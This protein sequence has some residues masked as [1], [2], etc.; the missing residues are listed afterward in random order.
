MK[1]KQS[2]AFCLA[3]M[4]VVS[5]FAVAVGSAGSLD[6]DEDTSLNNVSVT[7]DDAIEISH[8]TE[9]DDVRNNLSAD[10][11]LM[12]D[13]DENTEGYDEVASAS[14][15]DGKGF[16]PIG[17]RST[18][19]TGTFDGSE[20]TISNLTI[21]RPEDDM[22]GLFGQIGY[23]DGDEWESYPGYV[24]HVNLKDVN[25]T[26]GTEYVGGV[27]GYF[28]YGS[29]TESSVTG[30]VSGEHKV[31]GLVGESRDEGI[32][33][34]SATA[35]VSGLGDYVG[36]LVGFNLGPVTDS[37][38]TG[39]VSGDG[40]VG[41][42]IGY[43]SAKVS[44][45]YASGNV[46]GNVSVGGLIGDDSYSTVENSHY[47]I[48]E[49]LIN[50]EHHVTTGGL[51]NDQY[52]DWIDDKNLNIGDYGSLESA[53]GHYNISNVQ[54]LRDLLGFAWDDQY[55]FHL[56]SDIV[57]SGEQDLYI[58]YL[59]ADFDG[60]GH[61]VTNVEIDLPFVSNL[62]WVG[63]NNEATVRNIDLIINS[64]SG[65]EGV[66]G[67][68]GKNDGTVEN[69]SATGATGNVSGDSIVG[70][71]VGWHYSGTVTDS[72]ATVNVSGDD[73]VGGLVGETYAD[74]QTSYA[75]G[76]VNGTSRVGGLVGH[77]SYGMV[78]YS[79]ATGNV[80]GDNEV[81][82]L[83]GNN[84]NTVNDA[85]WDTETTGQDT[86]AGDGT[87]L[88]T[89][90]MKGDA[91]TE[92][93]NFDFENT[94]A[95]VDTTEISYPY[96]Q[97]NPQSP[98]PGL[99]S[100]FA[101]GDGSESDPYQIETV[102]QLQS[103][104]EDLPAHYMLISDIDASGTSE[105]N[106]GDGFTPI[107]DDE[108]GDRNQVP[109]TG[110]FDG[111]GYE[112]RDLYIGRPDERYVGLFG[113]TDDN[114][115]IT[116]LGVTDADVSGDEFVGG[117]VGQFWEDTVSGSYATGNVSGN[118]DVGGLIGDNFRG[119]VE[120]SYSTVDVIGDSNVGGL[121]GKNRISGTVEDS[122]FTG[123][124][125]G[126]TSVGGLAGLN[127]GTVSNSHYNIEEVL[128]NG[129]HHVTTSGLFNDQYQDW[130]DDKNLNI[131]DYG[132]LESVEGHY[133]I[134]DVQG[135]RDILGF[136][137]DDQYEFH[138]SS[139]I[140]LS[141][142]QDL[143]IP[144]LEADFDGNGHAVSNV[145]IDLP[146]VSKVGLFG[147]NN[148]GTVRDIGVENSNVSGNDN[149]GGLV[150]HNQGATVNNSYATGN[151]SG[152]DNVGGL[153]GNNDGTVSYDATV[154]NSYATGDVNGDERVGGLVGLND[155]EDPIENSY[156]TGDVSGYTNVGGLV[157]NNNQGT[158]DNSYAT[159]AVSGD[160]SEGGLIGR[161]WNGEVTDSYWDTETTGQ[162]T[163]AGDGTGLTT[164]EMKGD[165]ATE[166]MTGFDF[167]NTWDVVD[168]GT[169]IS[170]PYLQ[171]NTQSPAP[172]IE[173]EDGSISGTVTD[174]DSDYEGATVNLYEGND[175]TVSPIED[176]TT[177]ADGSYEFLGLEAEDTLYTVEVVEDGYS[178]DSQEVTLS[179]GEDA[180]GIDFTLE[181]T[182]YEVTFV[183]LDKDGQAYGGA[184]IVLTAYDDLTTDENGEAVLEVEHGSNV[185]YLVDEEGYDLVDETIEDVKEDI[186]ETVNL[187]ATTYQLK[188]N[189]DG[190]GTTAPREGTHSYD[191]GE[192]V[193]VTAT[194]AKG[195]EFDEW[196]GGVTG[197]DSTIEIT[198]DENKS[199][200]AVFEEV[201]V[202][203]H[204][205]EVEITEY[206]EELEVGRYIMVEY[207]VKNTGD[208]ED[209]QDIS[210]L[211]DGSIEERENV[212]LEPGENRIGKFFWEAELGSHLLTVESE[213]DEDT[214]AVNV[215]MEEP[216]LLPGFT[217]LLILVATIIA[218]AIY[219]KKSKEQ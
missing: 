111:Q 215:Q 114:A 181:V 90:E 118:K 121:V 45:S 125:S 192:E 146:S 150:G 29:V 84:E 138:L 87:G 104:Q 18:E 60:N 25:I 145:E 5:L 131:G 92:N 79:F 122:H 96:L 70:G 165:A 199:I 101:G 179:P 140:D 97:N 197:T 35:N 63:R 40:S 15:N 43:H 99:E 167:T 58:P 7:A 151:V 11:V 175:L 211:V 142:E 16:E 210:F 158:V 9:L 94:W 100:A 166:N 75:T 110:T 83:V 172:G 128:I 190:E 147:F 38:A 66:G 155:Y 161:D 176:T 202:G 164:A 168:N 112:I 89:A 156:A 91:A 183:V 214:V 12:S 153:V 27:V 22:N 81:G 141:G 1:I 200:T 28:A 67:L 206:D 56:S 74:V 194:P 201:E 208:V 48:D 207:T 135:L 46:S 193:T 203:Q 212:T 173:A 68:V 78:E 10:Y 59:E 109:F 184:E 116:D 113:Y 93:M 106:D 144:Y 17:D 178:D 198:M 170:Y 64:T 33:Q 134:S 32:H 34:S 24:E 71:L 191:H 102:D 217:S 42:L 86:S 88:T 2:V 52:Q 20:Y 219:Q 50:G 137:W 21:N 136:A 186:T 51:F 196:T 41:G 119:T 205:F 120:N 30:N 65:A 103:M 57:L 105:W 123:N 152:N 44:N 47:N 174:D 82:G 8:W 148:G 26:G 185:N 124:V 76:D 177:G 209:T 108:E 61:T 149:V 157:G 107:G 14:A 6:E 117:L 115:E 162:D 130:K 143:Y 188:I 160:Y 187:E 163:S 13:L 133:E 126:D 36:G 171:T 189:L 23:W 180:E 129:E 55:E 154:S 73:D 37:F 216:N 72:Y 213:N 218:V 53:G 182:T 4:L 127:D 204:I 85:Y 3:V 62:G 39:N 195:S 69:S 132:S 19:F 139:D 49:V 77:N 31:G 159:G 98:A 169:H 80:S 95:V 54:G